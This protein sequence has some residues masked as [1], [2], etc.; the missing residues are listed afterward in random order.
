M[1]GGVAPSLGL[2]GQKHLLVAVHTGDVD[3]LGCPDTH[4]AARTHILAAAALAGR[5]GGSAAAVGAGAG[6]LEAAVL[7]AVQQNVGQVML[8]NHFQKLVTGSG[9]RPSVLLG[10][11][12][13]QATGNGGI[14]ESA[15]V[16]G[17]APAAILNPVDMVVIVN[18]LMQQRCG[19]L[20]DG[21]GQGSGSD[22]DFVG[23]ADLGNP[24]VLPEGEVA[25]CLGGGLDGDG[26]S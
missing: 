14:P 20:L 13:N 23:A 3:G 17:V 24:S 25:V 21:T 18:H 26:G 8:Q 15:V 4:A 2:H 12:D 11:G 6:D 7:I 1:A 9:V 10:V 16:V 5:G 19:D 22:V